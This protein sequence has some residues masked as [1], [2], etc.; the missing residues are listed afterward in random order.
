MPGLA[1]VGHP[2]SALWVHMPWRQKYH[3]CC[4]HPTVATRAS[5]SVAL[6][7]NAAGLQSKSWKFKVHPVGSLCAKVKRSGRTEEKSRLELLG[8]G[9]SYQRARKVA[10]DFQEQLLPC[11][12][13]LVPAPVGA[14]A[15]WAAALMSWSAELEW[16]GV[17]CCWFKFPPVV[18]E[19]GV[20][21]L[22][23]NRSYYESVCL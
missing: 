23:F 11:G 2:V 12:L 15:C 9:S 20:F 21:P 13:G 8:E 17:T 7:R 19:G 6:P 18:R 4:R 22:C 3:C 14:G 16:R 5:C 10:E 1:Q